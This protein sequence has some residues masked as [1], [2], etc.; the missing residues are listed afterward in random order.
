MSQIA[1]SMALQRQ[2]ARSGT[3]FAKTSVPRIQSRNIQDIAIIRISGGRYHEPVN[4]H[5]SFPY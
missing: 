4:P 3:Q 5:S 1:S 2:L